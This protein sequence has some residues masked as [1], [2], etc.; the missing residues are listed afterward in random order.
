MTAIKAYTWILKQNPKF[1]NVTQGCTQK[2]DTE[3]GKDR[4]L[5]KYVRGHLLGLT[6]QHCGNQNQFMQHI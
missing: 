2:D 5:F 6:L 1:P 4:K 3:G